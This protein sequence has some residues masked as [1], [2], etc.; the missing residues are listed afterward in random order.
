[1]DKTAKDRMKRYR[2]RKRNGSVTKAVTEAKGVTVSD[3]TVEMVPASYVQGLNGKMYQ[4]LPERPR[5]L[6]LSDGQVLDRANQPEGMTSGDRILR[7]QACNESSYNF[8]SVKK[9]T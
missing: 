6:T 8:H 9:V 4:A 3:V 5:F 2:E 1:M 7:M